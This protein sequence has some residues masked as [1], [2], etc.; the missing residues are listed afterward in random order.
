MSNSFLKE[1]LVHFSALNFGFESRRNITYNKTYFYTL[2]RNPGI[3]VEHTYCQQ[4]YAVAVGQQ[5]S[6][7]LHQML[8]LKI[9]PIVVISS[10]V[11]HIF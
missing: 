1:L 5:L 8:D 9:F 3:V 11:V 4:C 7:Y 2:R 10:Q 6:N